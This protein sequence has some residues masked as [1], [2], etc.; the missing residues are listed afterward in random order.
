MPRYPI[1]RATNFIIEDESWTVIEYDH[2]SVPGTIYL[3]LT[4]NKINLIYDDLNNDIADTDKLAQY[5]LSV[6]AEPQQFV[7]GNIIEPTFTLTK[8]GIPYEAE[9][10]LLPTDKTLVRE[11]NGALVAQKEGQTQIIV[12]LKEYPSIYQTMTIDLVNTI[13]NFSAYI[14]GPDKIR[15]DREAT[16]T[17]IGTESLIGSVTFSLTIDSQ[18][19]TLAKIISINGNTCIVRANDKNKLT[20]PES[21]IVLTATYDGV[22]YTK[23]IAIIPLW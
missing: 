19:T 12:Q 16:Y 1:D 13:T 21:P 17:L 4:E 5:N 18:I 14:E 11:V 2:T 8:N 6:P 3:S 15:L 22:D 20:K 7:V 9:V 23:E 10:I